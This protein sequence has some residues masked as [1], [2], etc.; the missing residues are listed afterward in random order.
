M[1]CKGEQLCGSHQLQIF[2][3]L[4]LLCADVL[5]VC[6]WHLSQIFHHVLDTGK[7]RT[8]RIKPLLLIFTEAAYI[9]NNQD[10]II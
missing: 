10:L 8:G 5:P 1:F 7:H 6:G 3:S 2:R 9:S 4:P